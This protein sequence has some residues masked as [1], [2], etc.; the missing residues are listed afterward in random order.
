[1]EPEASQCRRSVYSYVIDMTVKFTLTDFP[2]SPLEQIIFKLKMFFTNYRLGIFFRERYRQE[3]I[4]NGRQLI[5]RYLAVFSQYCQMFFS[6]CGVVCPLVYRKPISGF[7]L[8][9][10]ERGPKI[11]GSFMIGSTCHITSC[12]EFCKSREMNKPIQ[13]RGKLSGRQ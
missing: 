6:W 5:A 3:Y 4:L 10:S 1:M 12:F 8:V 13:T 9:F 11:C 7:G 2:N